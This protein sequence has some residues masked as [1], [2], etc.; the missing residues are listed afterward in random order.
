MPSRVECSRGR[1]AR[2][3]SLRT[4]G[5]LLIAIVFFAVIA[6]TRKR[7]LDFPVDSLPNSPKALHRKTIGAF[8]LLQAA[9]SMELTEPRVLLR[10]AYRWSGSFALPGGNTGR[11]WLGSAGASH[12]R[13]GTDS[14]KLNDR[15]NLNSIKKAACDESQVAVSGGGGNCTRN[16]LYVSALQEYTCGNCPE[17]LSEGRREDA[18]LREL[19]AIWHRLTASVMSAIMD[20]ARGR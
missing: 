20:L 12:S 2:S 15:S 9:D 10:C 1:C 6:G 8:A 5:I 4:C 13:E 11:L 17:G 18:A 3:E 19:V 7:F 16:S 14:A